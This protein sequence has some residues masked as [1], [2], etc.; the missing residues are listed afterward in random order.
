MADQKVQSEGLRP[1]PRTWM[2]DF[3]DGAEHELL[4]MAD[5]GKVL[6]ENFDKDPE[7]FIAWINALKGQLDRASAVNNL[8]VMV[9][10]QF[11]RNLKA[12]N[13]K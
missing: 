2:D 3:L 4:K 1:V 11:V 13:E 7:A 10:H 8:N 9:G 12:K 5:T 6:W